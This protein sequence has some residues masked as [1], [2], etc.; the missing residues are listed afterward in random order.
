MIYGICNYYTRNISFEC[1]Q[2]Y[3]FMLWQYKGVP[4]VMCKKINYN[5]HNDNNE[6]IFKIKHYVV[7]TI[8]CY[9]FRG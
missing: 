4:S 9:S 3:C 2:A 7:D 5:K 1:H 8:L 6:H